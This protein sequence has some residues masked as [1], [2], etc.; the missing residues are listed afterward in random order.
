MLF[1]IVGKF[2]LDVSITTYKKLFP[3]PPP[4][5]TVKFGKLANIPFPKKEINQKFTYTIETPD[6]NLPTNIGTQAKVYFM[7]KVNS[8]LLSLDVAKEKAKALGY[9]G[10][11]QQK[12][13][14]LYSFKHQTFPSVLDM[15]IIT[16]NF[17]VSYDLI[18]DRTPLDTRPPVAEVAASN[19]RS[20]LSGANILPEEIVGPTLHSFFKVSDG[21]LVGAIALSEANLVKINLF[22][23][24]Y[25]KLPSVTE[26]PD[27]ANIWAVMSGAQDKIQQ[28]IA[29]EYHYRAV[30]ETKFSTYPI[31]TPQVAFKELQDGK[32]YI[33]SLGNHKDGDT[34]KIRRVY[35]AYFDPKNGSD[36]YQPI[37]V[38]D[39]ND[40]NSSF[41]A[42]TPA[43]TSTYYGN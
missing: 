41:V 28:I 26:N 25:D 12:S 37:Y 36:F 22:R 30:D 17:S 38:F 40:P 27:E 2:T 10:D 1:L 5:P 18:A 31:T 35:L 33:A 23:K 29:M 13:D 34:I 8:N 16:G 20:L 19:F 9:E 42:Y 14:T 32:A 39:E 43:V 11:P 3:A 6:G 15:N 21:K 7:P 24:D 4:A